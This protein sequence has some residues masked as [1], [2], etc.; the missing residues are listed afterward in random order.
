MRD[1]AEVAA[2]SESESG[3]PRSLSAEAV[4]RHVGVS[5]TIVRRTLVRGDLEGFRTRPRGQFRIPEDAIS[6]WFRPA[7]EDTG[8]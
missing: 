8:P 7:A 4:A 2:T 1:V 5:P 3:A 6:E